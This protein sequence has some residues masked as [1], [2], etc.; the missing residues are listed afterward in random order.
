[1]LRSVWKQVADNTLIIRLDLPIWKSDRY[2]RRFFSKT[3]QLPHYFTL[4]D[5]KTLMQT[6]PDYW[7]LLQA[8][9][10]IVLLLTGHTT[11]QESREVRRYT[12]PTP[13]SKEAML[14]RRMVS[15][16]VAQMEKASTAR[17]LQWE[18]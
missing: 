10:Q 1:M 7:K 9:K 15:Y 13:N 12:D 6:P 4:G 14:Q 5:I 3:F 17:Q 2:G 8:M 16:L 11:T 18:L